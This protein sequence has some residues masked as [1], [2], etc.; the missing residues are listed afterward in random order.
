MWSTRLNKLCYVLNRNQKLG[1]R[2]EK[3]FFENTVPRLLSLLK[4]CL[5][6]YDRFSL[7]GKLV[8]FFIVVFALMLCI[9]DGI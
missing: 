7:L 6:F 2:C 8:D 9:L 3:G 1:G 5:K 4:K